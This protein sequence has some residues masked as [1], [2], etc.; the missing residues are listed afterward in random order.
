MNKILT[1]LFFFCTLFSA[2]NAQPN[3]AS[4][5]TSKSNTFYSQKFKWRIVLPVGFVRQSNADYK[6]E[7]KKGAETIEK[8]SGEKI[9]DQTVQ[10]CSYKSGPFNYFE[11]NEQPYDAA[12]DGNHKELNKAVDDVLYNT[13]AKQMPDLKLDTVTYVEKIGGL[14]FDCFKLTGRMDE[15]HTLNTFLYT[16]LFGSND[17]TISIV[18]LDENKGKELLDSWQHSTFGK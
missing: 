3:A 8:A 1:F 11:A 5:D 17:L 9:D 16:R 15:S 13:F 7:H 6:N 4:A 18:Y 2:A 10:V 12:K 14:D